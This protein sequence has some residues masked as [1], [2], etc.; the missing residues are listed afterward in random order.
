MFILKSKN[1]NHLG[2]PL[3]KHISHDDKSLCGRVK[4]DK[5]WKVYFSNDHFFNNRKVFD[6]YG[7]NI[8]DQYCRACLKI[9]INEN[10]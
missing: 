10:L 9:Y 8:T 7:K 2:Y 6:D 4:A 5:N 1:K 3:K